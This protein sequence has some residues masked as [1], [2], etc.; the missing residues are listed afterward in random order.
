MLNERFKSLDPKFREEENY[1]AALRREEVAWRSK[2]DH[3]LLS[4]RASVDIGLVALRTVIIAN[5]G[6]IVALLAFLG[7]VWG[8]SQFNRAAVSIVTAPLVPFIVGLVLAMVCCLLAYLYQSAMT[9]KLE[10]EHQSW[11]KDMYS[12]A[13]RTA[14]TKWAG[15]LG[16]TMLGAGIASLT[17]FVWGVARVGSSFPT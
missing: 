1:K 8:R 2:F 13:P 9:A 6:A 14:L 7:P 17:G 10:H 3:M 15:W 12:P 11:A 5:A 16:L 4:D